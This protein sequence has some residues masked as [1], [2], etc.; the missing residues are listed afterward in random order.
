MPPELNQHLQSIPLSLT[1][2]HIS[3]TDPDASQQEQGSV[4]PWLAQP[5]Q[6]ME[7]FLKSSESIY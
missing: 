2:M 3:S 5:E 7:L 4:W 6:V 1:E